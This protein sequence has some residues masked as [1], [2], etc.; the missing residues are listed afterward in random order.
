MGALF[1]KRK[2]QKKI[3]IPIHA[4]NRM[5]YDVD[6]RNRRLYDVDMRK[7]HIRVLYGENITPKFSY[8]YKGIPGGWYF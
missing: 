7:V 5:L 4:K 1:S 3:K 2:I 6:M 8:T